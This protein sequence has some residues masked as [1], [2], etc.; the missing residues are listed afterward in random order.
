M[1]VGNSHPWDEAV[2]ALAVSVCGGLM[3]ANHSIELAY[4]RLNWYQGDG[5]IVNQD[6]RSVLHG[7][8]DFFAPLCA[9]ASFFKVVLPD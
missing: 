1:S 3:D 4:G 8:A 7:A 9:C 2:Q 6:H 5:R